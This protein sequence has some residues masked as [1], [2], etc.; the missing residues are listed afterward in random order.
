[1]QGSFR[2]SPIYV[3]AIS[4]VALVLLG[5]TVAPHVHLPKSQPKP[6][7]FY[8][9][10][11]PAGCPSVGPYTQTSG[12]GTEY[13]SLAA[14]T[15]AAARYNRLAPPRRHKCRVSAMTY[16]QYTA[17]VKVAPVSGPGPFAPPGVA[18]RGL[19]R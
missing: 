16:D 7:T 12:P 5:L 9:Y 10:A 13:S 6:P 14:A 11:A 1:M 19:P 15:R 8:T 3:I 2:D 18:N 17:I 4:I